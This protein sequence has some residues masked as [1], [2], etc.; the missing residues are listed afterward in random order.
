[1][2]RAS[3]PLTSSA[4]YTLLSHVPIRLLTVSVSLPDAPLGPAVDKGRAAVPPQAASRSD[5]LFKLLLIGDSSVG[6]SYLL[7][8]FADDSYVDTYIST[9]GVDFKFRKLI[10]YEPETCKLI[11]SSHNYENTPSA[12]ELGNL[13]TQMQATGADIVKIATTATE[14]VDVA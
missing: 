5:Y 12:E 11:V 2:S 14:I 10:Y 8:R 1:M 3:P 13:V 7:P 4:N 6:K 9:I